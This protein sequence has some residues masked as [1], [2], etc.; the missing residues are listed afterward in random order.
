MFLPFLE[1]QSKVALGL[2][3]AL[4]IVGNNLFKLAPPQPSLT[5]SASHRAV[6]LRS[7][8][9]D[10]TGPGASA[11]G[12]SRKSLTVTPAP[13]A[14]TQTQA[15]E[16]YGNL[17]LGF[18][19]NLGQADSEV[20]FLSRGSGYGF[21]LSSTEAVFS[22]IIP[23][24]TDAEKSL[25]PR[26]ATRSDQCPLTSVIR[27]QLLGANPAPQT[28]G[29]DEA[30]GKSNYFIGNDP[31]KWRTNVPN[32]A[33]VTYHGVYPGVDVVYYGNHR[34]LEFDY[35]IAPGANPDMI[36]LA[37]KGAKKLRINTQGNLVI[38][39]TAGEIQQHKP[40]IY[41]KTNGIKQYVEGHYLLRPD[42]TVG[43]EIAEYD[44]TNALVIDPCLVYSRFL[45]I[46]NDDTT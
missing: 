27:M 5:T 2:A 17:P 15:R 40:V 10:R 1:C 36:K 37:F 16:A 19:V 44:I 34:Q 3:L 35:V 38:Q 13:E 11:P 6:L 42:H 31:E 4:V 23:S 43:F 46:R 26:R 21:F 28:E 32:Y 25:G 39:T 30:P 7:P 14:I 33:R 18:E 9:V 20:R 29:G 22:L 8:T 45:G 41:Q 24:C 12:D